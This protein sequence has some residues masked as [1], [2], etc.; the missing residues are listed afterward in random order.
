MLGLDDGGN[1]SD[2]LGDDGLRLGLSEGLVDELMSFVVS[3]F[4]FFARG[5]LILLTFEDDA[6]SRFYIFAIGINEFSIVSN[7]THFLSL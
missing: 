1:V 3:A 6:L 7:H 2:D 5:I 4:G